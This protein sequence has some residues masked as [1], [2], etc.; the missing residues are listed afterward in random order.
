MDIH[1][2]G[3]MDGIAVAEE[4]RR[5][6]RLPVIFL[7]AYSED[8]TLDRAKLA[9]PLGYILKP[10]NDRELKSTIEI[11]LYKHRAE[12]EIRRLNRLYDVL[13]QVNQAIVHVRTREDLLSAV[14]RLVVERGAADLAWIGW[15]DRDT[16]RISPVGCFGNRTD[17]LSEADFYADN[18]PEGQAN[19][20]KAVREGKPFVCQE[21]DSGG[22]RYPSSKTPAQ[23]G[24]RSCG[25]FPLRF[26][27]QVCGVLSLCVTEQGFFREREM[28]L[29]T[30]VAASISFALDKIEDDLQR[31]QAQEAL[32]ESEERLTLALAA[33]RMGVWEWD[34]QTNGVFWSPECYGIVGAEPSSQTLES[35]TNVIHPED[36]SRVMAAV[37]QALAE[38]VIYAAE[39]RIVRADGEVRWLSNYGQAKYGEDGK[40]ARLVG[41]VSD[42]TERK[43][44]EEALKRSEATLRSVI[45]A[46]PVG[47]AVW[48]NDGAVDW[49][50]DRMTT[51]TG[52]TLEEVRGKAPSLLY[53]SSDEFHRIGEELC[54]LIRLESIGTAETRW[55]HKDGSLRDIHLRGAA[56]DPQDISA[57]IVF[58]AVDITELKRAEAALRESEERYRIAIE[59]SNDGIALARKDEL[60]FVNRRFLEIS[61]YDR[62]EEVLHIDSSVLIHPT[63]RER[64]RKL[65]EMRMRGEPTPSRYEFKGLRKDGTGI[66]I[67]ASV[68]S[69]LYRGERVSL[70]YFRD[71]TERKRSEEALRES[72]ERYRTLAEHSVDGIAIVSRGLFAYVNRKLCRM[73]GYDGP[74]EIVG[75]SPAIVVHPDD[76]EGVEDRAKRRMRGENVPS[77]HEFVGVTKAGKTLRIEISSALIPYGKGTAILAY[78]RDVTERR[79]LEDQLR[80]AQKLEAVG[81]LAAGIAHEINTP[82]QYVGDNLRFLKESFRDI[83]ALTH[84]NGK[85]LESAR[86]NTVSD[87]L[88]DEI[89]RTA[90]AMDIAYLESDIP[91]AIQQSVEGVERVT[92]I[93]RA[94]KEFSHPGTKEKTLVDINKALQNTVT[95]SRNEWKYVS[96]VVTELDEGLPLVPCLPGEFNQVILN[97]VINAAQAIAEKAGTPEE[98]GL[99]K[100]STQN[101]RRVGGDQHQ[102]HG[103]RDT[104]GHTLTGIRS[105]LH[106]EGGRQRDGPGTG[107]R[108]LHYR[109]Q[110]WR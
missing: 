68:A 42:I 25:S 92:T 47:I 30:E 26:Q 103:A 77:Q 17:M 40:P 99:I 36:A 41:T 108:P 105:L 55:I 104:A 88:V 31:K 52:Y 60:V 14:C 50:N 75:V 4:I 67:E 6:F 1:L 66:D 102:R 101:Q 11:G 44:A 10:F 54:N 85:L 94:M 49:I 16:S 35:F 106:H 97:I 95:V 107:H 73:F 19:P 28:E 18:R 24:F 8:M 3:A 70:I 76:A 12:E 98:K 64:L 100:I 23:F 110:A 46:S 83:I 72:Q 38:R 5:R 59:N 93:V 84:L 53:A 15:L 63:D 9:E 7:T 45:S 13:S 37:N 34:I 91:K 65:A 58:T 22:C 89:E 82:I 62:E 71:I 27:G 96:D 21:C 20:G 32:R 86:N 57:G 2:Q 39:F 74:E 51:I 87:G 56:M 43:R 69:F 79:R 48:R 109:G 61:G 78:Y 80:Q 90:A 29:L 81:Q 33:S